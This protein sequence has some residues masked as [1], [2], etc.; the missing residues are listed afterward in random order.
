MSEESNN[1]VKQDTNL[2]PLKERRSPLRTSDET[3]YNFAKATIEIAKTENPSDFKRHI[4][5]IDK[6]DR[7]AVKNGQLN[8]EERI[9]LLKEFYAMRN[10]VDSYDTLTGV[11]E[12]KTVQRQIEHLLN[13]PL[14]EGKKHIYVDLDI[15][16]LKEM[17]D[18]G[19]RQHTSAD[20]ALKAFAQFH[21]GKLAEK[22]GYK[23][24]MGRLSGDEFTM[25]ILNSTPQE[26]EDFF[27]E[28]ENERKDVMGKVQIAEG[29][30]NDITATRA[31]VSAE[32][33][34]TFATLH[35]KADNLLMSKKRER[36]RMQLEQ[37]Q[38][39][40]V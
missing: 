10:V 29:L 40:K 25:L 9:Q 32:P 18:K 11:L 34:D 12:R 31:I 15:N 26:I 33:T 2:Q 21:M 13:T 16:G 36:N 7:V 24:R 35:E 28:I 3:V 8:S 20:E 19:K 39:Q 14:E 6:F 22:F 4:D 27:N 23:Q 38:E 37:L 5:E 17:N 30:P 1:E